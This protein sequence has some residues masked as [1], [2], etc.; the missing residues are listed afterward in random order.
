MD[1][2]IINMQKIIVEISQDRLEKKISPLIIEK[3]KTK[4][5]SYIGLEMIIDTV[6]SIEI[7]NLE[8][9]LDDL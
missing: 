9:Y 6:K 1:E 8:R 3:I 4:Y 7:E 5:H 2:G